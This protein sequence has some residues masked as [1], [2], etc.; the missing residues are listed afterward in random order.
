MTG[1]EHYREA[2]R[3]TRLLQNW[4]E[5]DGG[6]ASTGDIATGWQG[7]VHLA[8]L[9]VKLAQVAATIGTD[10]RVTQE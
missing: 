2:E 10:E 6:G 3:I 1:A 9:H 8:D 7:L 5:P 4:N